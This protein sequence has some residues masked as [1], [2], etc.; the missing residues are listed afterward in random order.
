MYKIT[1]EEQKDDKSAMFVEN[2]FD[3]VKKAKAA[4]AAA[5]KSLAESKMVSYDYS[6]GDISPSKRKKPRKNTKKGT[7]KGKTTT[8]KK[9]STPRKQRTP[10]DPNALA[11]RKKSTT[12]KTPRKNSKKSLAIATTTAPT[13]DI[14][15]E[16]AAFILSSISQRSFDSFYN[17][18][19][20]SG[21]SKIQI[22]LETT[23]EA[24]HPSITYRIESVAP[25]QTE[26]I[27]TV[28]LDHN[29]HGINAE[30]EVPQ[31]TAQSP[32]SENMNLLFAAVAELVETPVTVH[33]QQISAI[34]N[35]KL[36]NGTVT[37]D[38]T[39]Y[40]N[41]IPN[42][43][44]NS[45]SSSSQHEQFNDICQIHQSTNGDTNNNKYTTSPDV[46]E[47]LTKQQQ[48]CVSEVQKCDN[49]TAAVKKR[50]LRQAT[51]EEP[52]TVTTPELS[53]IDVKAP[54]K[55]RRVAREIED[56]INSS[57]IKNEPKWENFFIQRESKLTESIIIPK[58]VDS[59]SKMIVKTEVITQKLVS[60]EI[61][62]KVEN[63][64][65]ELV[66]NNDRKMPTEVFE[67]DNLQIQ[68]EETL[69]VEDVSQTDEKALRLHQPI[70]SSNGTIPNF[71]EP[72]QKTA[73]S[74]EKMPEVKE[75]A[76]KKEEEN[77]TVLAD[78]ITLKKDD[79][80]K[81]EKIIVEESKIPEHVSETSEKFKIIPTEV[82]E[83]EHLEIE[84]D[85]EKA[86]SAIVESAISAER[87][88]AKFK[89]E[90]EIIAQ[91]E[92]IEKQDEPL[93]EIEDEL[94]DDEDDSSYWNVVNEFHKEQLEKLKA[95]NKRFC[96]DATSENKSS[97]SD[98]DSSSDENNK[99]DVE[100]HRKPLKMSLSF[101][102]PPPLS[103]FIVAPPP[104]Q[105]SMSDISFM[106]PRK[107]RWITN[108]N[109]NGF[110]DKPPA[111][112]YGQF[113]YDK[114]H[115]KEE[116]YVSNFNMN[117]SYSM[118][119]AQK[120]THNTSQV[121]QWNSRSN[122]FEPSIPPPSHVW[123]HSEPPPLALPS[124]IMDK[125][126]PFTHL[127]SATTQ[128]AAQVL[129]NF[130][131]AATV[132]ETLSGFTREKII[133]SLPKTKNLSADPRL[134]PTL[135]TEQKIDDSATPKKKVR[136]VYKL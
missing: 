68:T 88:I 73:E 101:D 132:D 104:Y 11:K 119:R 22:P 60:D 23:P 92:I 106:D 74:V 21:T 90:V 29:Y 13:A 27:R 20:G 123:N 12:P 48:C 7:P 10:K 47:N 35:N 57:E 14:D 58:V 75:E 42:R 64:K 102:A 107:D 99:P 6:F 78:N 44:P 81:T 32:A 71:V 77:V 93:D 28:M 105:R 79:E 18:L 70:L 127:P 100:D 116:P 26:M 85:P 55:K 76:I 120:A 126:P 131:A 5:A 89:A 63:I 19:N 91:P 110:Y 39:N 54:P 82:S 129:N 118:Y 15:D 72:I 41:I 59:E 3:T 24:F 8:P 103:S 4:K 61:E 109:S 37:T 17:R 84:E 43:K 87:E 112:Q 113:F 86:I 51:K 34:H 45:S 96:Y 2:I 25:S 125:P 135:V 83:N 97:T 53:P 122:G 80:Q 115:H 1:S 9:K 40:N 114:I 98:H 111:R 67:K 46:R 128:T 50:W 94:E 31:P 33:S 133:T 65:T 69:K 38:S 130:R 56:L 108:G 121:N 117:N 124:F 66:E 52:L 16:E 95:S 136:I 30:P 49:A 134:N 36:Q 62:T